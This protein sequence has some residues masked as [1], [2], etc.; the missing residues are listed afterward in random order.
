MFERTTTFASSGSGIGNGVH[1]DGG[2][3]LWDY[4]INILKQDGFSGMHIY[5]VLTVLHEYCNGCGAMLEN[6]KIQTE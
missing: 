3:H 5:V 2:R 4:S 6:L 1:L